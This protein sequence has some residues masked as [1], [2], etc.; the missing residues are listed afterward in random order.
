[1]KE[2]NNSLK[3]IL[4]VLQP[5]VASK[6]ELEVRSL[7]HKNQA[8]EDDL[9][10]TKKN[11]ADSREKQNQAI[12]DLQASTFDFQDPQQW[13]LDTDSTIRQQLGGLEKSAKSWCRANCVK[14]LGDLPANPPRGWDA[15]LRYDVKVFAQYDEQLPQIILQALLMH[16][17]Y[18]EIFA[19][20]LFFL[21]W[22]VQGAG[23]EEGGEVGAEMIARQDLSEVMVGIIHEVTQ[24]NLAEGNSWRCNLLR[25]LDPKPTGNEPELR[26][27]V[28]K[29]TKNRTEMAREAAANS[30]M[31]A[32]LKNSVSLPISPNSLEGAAVA[33]LRQIF[34]AAAHLSYKLW[35]RKSYLEV[36]TI[37]KIPDRYHQ[38]SDLLRAHS[39]HVASLENDP[40]GLDNRPVDVVVHPALIVHGSSDGTNYE[41][42]RVWMQA[43]VWMG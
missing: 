6:W 43:V 17:I 15:V 35:L 23:G 18:G 26:L 10:K 9:K 33:E 39:R 29:A 7:T 14:R 42:T 22:R 40:A 13:S 32:F 12:R 28:L 36:Q 24:G 3:G 19:K 41:P 4:S 8:I 34:V 30:L 27:L 16:C 38:D 31:E 1:M 2:T 25:L 11:L 21:P 5:T 37:Q 20:P